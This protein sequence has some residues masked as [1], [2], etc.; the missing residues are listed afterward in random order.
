MTAL[1]TTIV[2]EMK[3]EYPDGR[4]PFPAAAAVEPGAVLVR[5]S[6]TLAIYD[7]LNGISA[8]EA[9][10]GKLISPQPVTPYPTVVGAVDPLGPTWLA[11][12]Q[13]Y[14]DDTAK[15]ITNDSDTG[16]NPLVGRSIEAMTAGKTVIHVEAT[17]N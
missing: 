8:A 10:A 16:A 14:W 12:V 3:I 15:V 9:T 4:Y 11:G 6:G 2:N 1:P 17:P 5:P 7:G 13:V